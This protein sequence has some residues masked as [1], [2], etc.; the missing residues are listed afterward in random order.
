MIGP[1][2]TSGDLDGVSIHAGFPNPALDGSLDSLDLN[3]LL[4]KHTAGTYFMRISG[5]DWQSSG[6]FAGDII[7]VDRVVNAQP[8]D[9]IV[10]W[11]GESFVVSLPSRLPKGTPHWGVVTTTIHPYRDY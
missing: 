5:N 2:I 3:R 7:I 1:R 9:L 4:I 8:N 11:Q 6:I 10:W